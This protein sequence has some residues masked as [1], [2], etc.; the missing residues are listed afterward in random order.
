MNGLINSTMLAG[1]ILVSSGY[2]AATAQSIGTG[3]PLKQAKLPQPVPL[4]VLSRVVVNDV[5]R[6]TSVDVEERNAF[7]SEGQMFL[8][9]AGLG[10]PGT[11]AFNR[12]NNGPDHRDSTS[13]RL[14]GYVLEGPIGAAWTQRVRHCPDLAHPRRLQWRNRGLRAHAMRGKSFRLQAPDSRRIRLQRFGDEE[15]LLS[16]TKGAVYRRIEPDLRPS[17]RR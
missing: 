10:E 17:T 13:S 5:D 9:R 12:F 6:L 7:P 2:P 4:S 15:S 1:A 3:G 16:L 14:P 8:H 11:T